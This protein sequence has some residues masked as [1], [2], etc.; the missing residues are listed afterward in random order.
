VSAATS[1]KNAFEEIGELHESQNN[2]LKVTLNLGASGDLITQITGS[3]EVD[4]FASTALKDM[5]DLDKSGFVVTG[6][7]TNFMSNSMVLIVPLSTKFTIAS[8]EDLKQAVI[9]KIAIENPKTVP[10]GRYTDETFQ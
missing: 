9:R 7:R 3:A 2:N 8:L 5:D 6:K 1:L 10:V 4:V